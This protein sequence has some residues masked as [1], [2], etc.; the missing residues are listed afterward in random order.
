MQAD[1]LGAAEAAERFA[2]PACG[3]P[4]GRPCKTRGADV[5]I[6]YHTP[7]FILV[8]A[9]GDADEVVVPADRCPGDRWTAGAPSLVRIGYVC[10]ATAN[11]DVSE[12]FS[13]LDTAGCA[14]TFADTVG[15]TA[16][17]RPELTRAL[18][19]AAGQR[20]CAERQPVALTV[21]ELA[22]LARTAA[23]LIEVAGV[24]QTADIQLEVRCGPLTGVHDPGGSG[25]M[26][27]AVLAAA[28]DL[29]REH[30]RQLV[31]SGQRA[32]VARGNHGGRPR[33]FDEVMLA[34]ARRLYSEGVPVPVIAQRLVISTGKN[35][36]RHPSLAS[37]YRALSE[38]GAPRVDAVDRSVPEDGP[39]RSSP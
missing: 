23:E 36:G 25:S 22:R 9:L 5:A 14:R 33:V 15:P 16:G 6:G 17:M 27:F 29:D 3:A 12:Q 4:A 39:V 26:L 18:R 19:L 7:R 11:E 21:C 10:A 38:P 30:R 34:V 28:A 31:R 37:V 1:V 13:Q 8:P 20:S 32:A 24:L 35:A 2:C